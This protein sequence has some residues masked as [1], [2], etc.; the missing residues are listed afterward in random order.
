V[1]LYSFVFHF[2]FWHARP[3]ILETAFQLF[4]IWNVALY[5]N[6]LFMLIIICSYFCFAIFAVRFYQTS[7]LDRGLSTQPDQLFLTDQDLIETL[8]DSLLLF[9]ARNIMKAIAIVF[10]GLIAL[11]AA[12]TC[13]DLAA[14]KQSVACEGPK[15]ICSQDSYQDFAMYTQAYMDAAKKAWSMLLF[16]ATEVICS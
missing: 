10:L 15:K 16:V 8:S 13:D 7:S 9:P 2:K 6:L 3:T 4:V 12:L 11:S 5:C 14:A 1:R